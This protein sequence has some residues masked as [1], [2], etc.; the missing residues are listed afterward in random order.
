MDS[1]QTILT[2][3]GV[4]AEAEDRYDSAIWNVNFQ[5]R[6]GDL[7]L[8]RLEDCRGSLPLAD[9]AEGL[10]D[11]AEGTAAFLDEPWQSM[12]PRRAARNRG[13]IGRVFDDH[14]WIADLDVADNVTL[15][16]RHQAR[17]PPREIEDEAASLA[18]TFGLPGLPRRYPAESRPQDLSRAACVRALLGSPRFIILEK[19]ATEPFRDIRLPA[20]IVHG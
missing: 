12:S 3:Q 14:G 4:T 13:T 6:P 1:P 19:P 17:R 8:V 18:R 16:Q 20:L 10:L 5:L 7:A 15:A 2:L 11:P 9:V